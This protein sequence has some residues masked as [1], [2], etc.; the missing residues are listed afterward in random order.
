MTSETRPALAGIHHIKLPVSDLARSL[1]FYEALLGAERIPA[2]DHKHDDGSV[3]AYICDV[4]G[5]GTKLELR[6][7]PKH[8]EAQRTNELMHT[9]LDNM[10]DGVLLLDQDF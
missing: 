3:Y 4:P 10:N 7:N 8:A 2:L 6:L 9:V 1:S 5:L